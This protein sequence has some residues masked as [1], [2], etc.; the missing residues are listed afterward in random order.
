[1]Y[2][3]V[4][5]RE[6]HACS[7]NF[8]RLSLGRQRAFCIYSALCTG[9][10]RLLQFFAFTT[11]MS[12]FAVSVVLAYPGGTIEEW[13]KTSSFFPSAASC[14]KRMKTSRLLPSGRLR[15][16]IG[17]GGRASTTTVPSANPDITA[18]HHAEPGELRSPPGDRLVGTIDNGY[19][20]R[21]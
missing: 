10:R 9:R 7:G 1:M 13:V 5:P 3:A 6:I 11:S 12:M 19:V 14:A 20:Q 4:I 15:R 16:V 2:R 8:D 17:S 18:D 21:S